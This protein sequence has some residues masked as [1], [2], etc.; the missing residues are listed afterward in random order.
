MEGICDFERCTGCGLCASCCPKGCIKMKERDS[1]GHLYPIINTKD[2][3]DCGLCQRNCPIVNPSEQ[4]EPSIAYA[5]WSKD[6]DDYK[7][8]TSGGAASVISQ[9]VIEHGGVVY[10]C[11]MLP[12][13]EIKHIRID[14][15]SD[16]KKLKGSKY[17]QSNMEDVYPQLKEDVKSGCMTLFIG[18][19]C[20]AAAVKKLFKIQPDNLI[21][22]DLICHGVPS[23]EILKEH[24]KRV[25]PYPHYDNVFFRDGKLNRVC[26]KVEVDEEEVYSRY[27][28]PRGRRYDEWYL[29]TFLDGYTYRDSC[30]HCR[31]ACIERV[32]D[33]TIGDF[34]GLGKKI[35]AD[36]IPS[37]PYGCSVILPSTECGKKIVEELGSKLHLYERTV[38]E[39]A[40]GNGQ[41]KWPMPLTR[42]RKWFRKLYPII[43]KS[44]YRLVTIDKYIMWRVKLLAPQW[45]IKCL[46]RFI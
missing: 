5:A 3:I 24:I 25:V 12:D 45:L 7:S 4:K 35:P 33:I 28:N 37:R 2:C 34:W 43:G 41:L 15:I 30:Y 1:F 8:S 16:I 36:Y 22:V 17:V 46:K 19:P 42:R 10:G 32:S 23:Q 6:E 39:A 44:A 38:N 18:T 11:A 9:Y 21:L 40:R 13:V 14:N 20:Q 29:D 27:H 31:F 26:L